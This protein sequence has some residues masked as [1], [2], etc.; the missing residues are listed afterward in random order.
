MLIYTCNSLIIPPYVQHFKIVKEEGYIVNITNLKTGDIIKN[1]KDMCNLL[2]EKISSGSSKKGTAKNWEMYIQYEKQGQKFFI[3]NIYDVPLPKKDKRS[4]GNRRIYLP[5]VEKIFLSYLSGL[6]NKTGYFTKKN[7][8]YI[9][10]M[11]NKFHQNISF[12]DLSAE[13]SDLTYWQLEKFY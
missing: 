10:G 1:Y 3:L 4:N 11:T 6:E 12:I 9:L 2:E 13:N 8:L 5:Y 7:L